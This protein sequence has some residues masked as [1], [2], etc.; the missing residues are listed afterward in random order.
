MA[1]VQQ[2]VVYGM[3]ANAIENSHVIYDKKLELLRT[4]C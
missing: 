3:G 2:V 1:T 4:Q